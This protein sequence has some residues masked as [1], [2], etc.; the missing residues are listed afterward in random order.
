MQLRNVKVS[1]QFII[2]VDCGSY[3]HNQ[4]WLRT[5]PLQLVVRSCRE[6]EHSGIW[7]WFYPKHGKAKQPLTTISS[8]IGSFENDVPHSVYFDALADAVYFEEAAMLEQLIKSMKEKLTVEITQKII[9][10]QVTFGNTLLIVFIDLMISLQLFVVLK[11][12]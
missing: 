6:K 5:G 1:A 9:N 7:K 11:K 4:W 8:C 10:T 2:D 12:L 3:Q